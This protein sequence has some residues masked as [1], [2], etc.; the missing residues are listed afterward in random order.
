M[1]VLGFDSCEKAG[2]VAAVRDGVLLAERFLNV[3]LT[4]SQTLAPMAQGLLDD[5]GLSAREVD[6]FAVN[7]GPGSFTG[8][9]IGVSLCMALARAADKPCCAVSSL[10]ALAKNAA[11]CPGLIIPA[12]DARRA[13]VYT[14]LFESDGQT[15]TRL[16]PDEAL[17][18]AEVVE[19]I[20]K[21]QKPVFLVG[22]G[23]TLCYNECIGL[24]QVQLV[25][26][27]SLFGRA[28]SVAAIGQE[29]AEAGNTVAPEALEGAYLR[30]SQ[31][32]RERRAKEEGK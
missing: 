13:Q 31:A 15:L 27:G 3:G 16:S 32:E 5:L 30:P 20:K 2:S 4:H 10:H 8:I 1:L 9:R 17:S 19:R 6:A 14:A 11:F 12:M 21:T 18:I 24:K 23:A 22:E 25:R 26:G 29:L 28:S 7:V